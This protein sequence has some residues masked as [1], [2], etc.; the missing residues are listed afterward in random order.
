MCPCVN[1]DGSKTRTVRVLLH[2]FLP[3]SC[4][5]GFL[6]ENRDSIFQLYWQLVNFS[7]LPDVAFFSA[8]LTVVVETVPDFYIHAFLTAESLL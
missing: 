3:S 2:A 7:D 5:P 1:M 4:E 8:G 6:S